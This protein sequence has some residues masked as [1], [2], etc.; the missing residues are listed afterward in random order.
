MRQL[1]L[2]TKLQHLL[3]HRLVLCLSLSAFSSLCEENTLRHVYLNLEED[4]AENIGQRPE[5]CAL[6]LCAQYIT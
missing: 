5:D 6:I 4:K 3:A 1:F 2:F